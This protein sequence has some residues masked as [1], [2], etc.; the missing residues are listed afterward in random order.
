MI[1][2]NAAIEAARAG[3][4][5]M[6]FAVLADEVRALA[7]RSAQA[8]KDTSEKIDGAVKRS[9]LGG[10]AVANVVK[11]LTAMDAS[12]QN[13]QQ[14]FTGIVGQVKLLDEVISQIAT[15]SQEQTSRLTKVKMAVGQMDKLSQSNAAGAQ[16][17]ANSSGILNSQATN[18][19]LA[20]RDLQ[21]ISNGRREDASSTTSP[22]ARSLPFD[23]D[24]AKSGFG[25]K[26]TIA[27]A[28]A[29]A[30]YEFQNV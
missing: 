30:P 12:A 17:S 15:A 2:L 5:G 18:L 22:S 13:I 16:E 23:R 29:S 9:E 7:Q 21:G 3:E 10:S 8:A 1:A 11:S 14:V 25:Q 27:K 26:A 4:V 19:Q 24:N 20:I 6:G 28:K